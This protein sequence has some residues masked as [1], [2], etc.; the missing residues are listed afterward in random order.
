MRIKVEKPIV[1]AWAKELKRAGPLEIGGVLFGEQIS[2]GCFR[3]VEA[4]RQHS[5]RGARAVSTVDPTR[6]V[7]KFW[8]CIRVTAEIRH[9]STTSANGTHI[10]VHLCYRVFATR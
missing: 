5:G 10:P 9:S 2:E 4:K 6:L 7:S 3:I 8:H 1:D